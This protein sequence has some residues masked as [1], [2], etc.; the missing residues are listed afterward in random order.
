MSLTEHSR[1]VLS[2]WPVPYHTSA[3][4][5]SPSIFTE[6]FRNVPGSAFS[7]PWSLS[8]PLP[9]SLFLSP[10]VYLQAAQSASPWK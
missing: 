1:A 7:L 6:G 5:L 10:E 8:W 3:S 9:C 2:L 4:P